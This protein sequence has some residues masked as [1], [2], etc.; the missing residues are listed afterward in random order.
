M[1]MGEVGDADS[2]SFLHTSRAY[3]LHAVSGLQVVER[4]S[5]TL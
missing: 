1:G 3:T 5:V 4:L 2:H